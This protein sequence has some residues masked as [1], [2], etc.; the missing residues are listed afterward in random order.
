M[1]NS[2][3]TPEPLTLTA[4]IS[5]LF[6]VLTPAQIARIAVHGRTR[7]I[8]PGDVLIHAG[9]QVTPF[10]V[11]TAGQV[12]IVQPSGSGENLVAVHNPGQFTGE[13]QLISG[14]RA[15]VAARA[16]QAGE[17]IELDREHLLA[18]VQTDSELSEI[19]MRAF[20]L[21]RVELIAH[22]FGDVV[23]IGSN[24]CSG[25]L[26]VKEFLTRNNHPYA[27]VDLDHDA[28]VQTLLDHFK[29]FAGDIPVLICGG[30]IVLRN[31]TNQQ[32]ADC[33][34]FNNA[35]DQTQIR[36][37]V[38]VGAGP[39]GL[40]AAVYAA[41]EGL[42]VLVIEANAPGGQAGS[43]SRIENYLGFPTGI[44]GQALAARAY[45]QAQKFGAQ[46]IIAQHAIRLGC[47]RKPYTVEVSTG[48]CVPTRTIIIATGAEYRKPALD[49]LTRFEGVGV[50]YGATFMEAQ[51]CAGEEV[52]VVGGGNS[53]GQAAV[54]LAQ[55]AK[56]VHVL[57]RADGLSE[58]MSRYLIRRI[59]DN[60]AIILHTQT[61]IVALE[62]SQHLERVSWQARGSE[63]IET[64]AIRHVFLMTGA[65]PNSQWLGG[66]VVRDDKGFIKTGADL[67][68][69]E[70]AAAHWPLGRAPHLLETS[71]PGV[72]A[73]GDIRAG[74]VKRVASAVGEGSIS[75]SFVHQVLHE[76]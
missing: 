73:V 46:V 63:D 27:Y 39:S 8:Q 62:G 51:L 48:A 7:N 50:Y 3:P 6:P 32:I 49:N 58:S 28:D 65:A 12:E 10:F 64:Q 74:N 34:G 30:D 69:D 54:F 4:R 75:V 42:D 45:T 72:F 67:S 2:S 40:A 56:R 53:A 61:T 76:Y 66:C 21:R 38:I 23:L 41:S 43:S 33:L 60:P 24:N 59:E 71:V 13:V 26:R 47:D 57:I 11:V 44:S 1:P 35:I 20:I 15:L 5:Q 22:G 19:I 25:T 68:P 9:A 52:V 70:L 36:D 55:T 17:V 16:S 14:R 37:L 31:P 29:V 18:L